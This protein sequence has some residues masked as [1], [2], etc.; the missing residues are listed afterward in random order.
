MTNFQGISSTKFE[1]IRIN[2]TL[3]SLSSLPRGLL[4]KT[5]LPISTES[6]I[7]VCEPSSASTPLPLR[8][9]DLRGKE[10]EA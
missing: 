5:S 3:R 8:T 9:D 4:A 6:V 10:G 7:L 1:K 2:V